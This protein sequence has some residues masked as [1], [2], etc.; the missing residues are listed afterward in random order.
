MHQL[1]T[2]AEALKLGARGLAV[3]QQGLRPES[4]DYLR[5]G[6]KPVA[7]LPV[8]V[9]FLPDGVRHIVDGR[10]RI[11]IAREHGLE[12][13]R[14]TMLGYGPRGGRLWKYTGLIPI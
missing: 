11:T 7:S 6:G 1:T 2:K 3:P 4:F 12:W 14:G 13:I 10:H 9:A 5:A 8:M